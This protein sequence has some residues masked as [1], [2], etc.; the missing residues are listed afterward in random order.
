[1]KS[2]RIRILYKSVNCF[3]ILQVTAGM[4]HIIQ[5][6]SQIF[7]EQRDLILLWK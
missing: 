6:Q 2:E 3:I 7:K 5:M 1:M 4:Y